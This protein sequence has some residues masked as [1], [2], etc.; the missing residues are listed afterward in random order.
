MK[1]DG[2]KDFWQRI[3][4]LEKS[5]ENNIMFNKNSSGKIFIELSGIRE[6]EGFFFV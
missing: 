2:D 4:T 5:Q 3:W 1:W 6:R